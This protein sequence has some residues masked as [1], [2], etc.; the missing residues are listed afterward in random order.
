MTNPG[1]CCVIGG[2]GFIGS[3]LTAEARRRGWTVA[4][5]DRVDYAIHAG[6]SFDLVLN[7]NGNSR[8]YMA[9]DDPAR[10]FDL[11]VTSV[12]HSL[13]DF[14]A[15]RY[16]YISSVDVYPDHARPACNHEQAGI[17]LSGLKPYGAH[18][19]MA[20]L[21]VR[22]YARNWLILRVGGVVG[23]DL[24]KNS[25][26]DLLRGRPLRVHPDSFYQYLH[27]RD[28]ARIAF[29]LAEIGAQAAIYNVCGDG[30]ISLR[31]IAEMIPGYV[32]EPAAGAL[33]RE[34]YEINIDGIKALA[35]IPRTQQTLETFVSD[36]TAGRERLG[37]DDGRPVRCGDAGI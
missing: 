7:A 20:E 19:Y 21:L 25:V 31:T 32:E 17:E 26:Y 14:K 33:P 11:S 12:M 30:L 29:D 5:A 2:R 24:W 1:S 27:I 16:V 23:P 28:L 22:Q 36:V 34:H 10:D 15:S 37:N 13:H 9:Q 4:V 3:A 6:C 8:K 18:K 35:A